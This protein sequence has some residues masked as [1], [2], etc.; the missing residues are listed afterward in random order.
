[1][2]KRQE[3]EGKGLGYEEAFCWFHGLIGSELKGDG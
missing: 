1:V 2:Q 3:T